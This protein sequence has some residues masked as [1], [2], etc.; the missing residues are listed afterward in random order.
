MKSKSTQPF[1][2][3][4]EPFWSNDPTSCHHTLWQTTSRTGR[5]RSIPLHRN[6]VRN[7]LL[8]A[9][10]A[11]IWCMQSAYRLRQRT[12][13]YVVAQQHRSRRLAPAYMHQDPSAAECHW[14][15]LHAVHQ[16]ATCMLH[17]ASILIRSQPYDHWSYG[18]L[19]AACSM[20]V[21]CM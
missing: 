9:Y 4:P 8:G 12:A 3:R 10:Y 1:H 13:L 11:Y 21:A 18:W 7:Q 14:T 16:N 17:A 5:L 2:F 15:G 20:H 19:L 6:S